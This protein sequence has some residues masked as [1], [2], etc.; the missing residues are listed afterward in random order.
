[1]GSD[2]ASSRPYQPGDDVDTIDWNASARL[3]SA[4]GTDEFIVRERFAEEAPCVVILCDRRPEMA[5]Y[6]QGLPWLSKPTVM[7]EAGRQIADSTAKS[8]GARRLPRLRQRRARAVLAAAAQP[9][10]LLARQ[11]EPPALARVQGAEGQP[12]AG[13]SPS[14]ST[15]GARC[16]RKLRLRPVR[17]PRA[18]GTGDVGDRAR[19][20]LG[21]RARDHPGPDLGAE[22]PTRVLGGR[23]ACRSAHG[24]REGGPAQPAR[25]VHGARARTRIASRACSRSCAVRA[26]AAAPG[27]HRPERDLQ[28][29]HDLGRA[30]PCTRRERS[31]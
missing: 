30:S 24:W 10:G 12:H 9:A 8:R 2:V 22:L 19:A 6:P 18:A 16:P 28:A 7:L 31:V 17:L 21:D 14:R 26:R 5:L 25:R 1:M 20:A 3:S 4:R 13:V 29:L 15:R 27:D 23:P 11:G